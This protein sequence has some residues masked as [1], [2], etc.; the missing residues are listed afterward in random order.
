MVHVFFPVLNEV[1]YGTRNDGGV[2][3]FLV[4]AC[5]FAWM[6]TQN[7][8]DAEEVLGRLPAICYCLAVIGGFVLLVFIVSTAGS[9]TDVE[10]G[11]MI[12][13]AVGFILSMFVVGRVIELLQQ[14]RD[15]VRNSPALSPNTSDDE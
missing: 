7:K 14:I 8:P 15:A 9:L 2:N 10:I 13:C 12:G 1:C 3:V 5:V 6:I 11:A 4:G